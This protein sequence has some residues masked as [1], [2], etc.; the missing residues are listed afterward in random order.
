MKLLYYTD[1]HAM[2]RRPKHR[3]D[4]YVRAIMAKL[5]EI[6]QIAADEA[7]DFVLFGGDFFDKHRIYSYPLI[8]EL[9]EAVISADVDTMAVIGQHDLK[10]YNRGSY[11][12]S[13]L[14]FMEQ[15]CPR[16]KTLWEPMKFENGVTI[17]PCHCFDDLDE[18]ISQPPRGRGK[19]ILVAHKLLDKRRQPFPGF[20]C[21]SD[22]DWP[23]NLVLSGDLHSGYKKHKIG[24]TIL[25]NPGSVGRPKAD[26]MERMPKVLIVEVEKSINVRSVKLA[27]AAPFEDIY[28][29][30]ALDG[31]DEPEQ[32]DADEFVDGISSV[33]SPAVNVFEMVQHVSTD[34]HDRDVLD[35]IASKRPSEDVG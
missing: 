30:S 11:D 16:W 34:E 25:C 15:W 10:G 27:C 21:T 19:K 13:C 24:R 23:Y 22:Y 18:K 14:A 33:Q 12:A 28:A 32:I 17:V 7:V 29:E 6:Y 35:Y 31:L 26:D 1:L 3:A 8:T 4:D 2:A 20:L 5:R 9:M